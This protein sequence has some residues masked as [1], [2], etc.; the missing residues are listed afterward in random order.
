M[1]TGLSAPGVASLRQAQ[2][3]Q[4]LVAGVVHHHAS[5]AHRDGL[6]AVH[7]REVVAGLVGGTIGPLRRAVTDEPEYTMAFTVGDHQGLP[8]GGEVDACAE[9]LLGGAAP[10]VPAFRLLPAI[11]V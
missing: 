1:T 8:V 5:I 4:A 6:R 9:L 2:L 3:E 7:A 10:G 11:A